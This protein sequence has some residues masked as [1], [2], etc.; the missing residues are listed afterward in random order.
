MKGLTIIAGAL[1][2]AARIA[3]YVRSVSD[4]YKEEEKKLA[5]LDERLLVTMDRFAK[6]EP[7]DLK[8][9]SNIF[10]PKFR[11][12]NPMVTG[13]S[14]H[15]DKDMEPFFRFLRA[16]LPCSEEML[17]FMEKYDFKQNLSVVS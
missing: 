3:P 5:S 15:M 7:E 11:H 13:L 14:A 17:E 9:F 8:K 2:M 12:I 1:S 10:R 4:E 6:A 16:S